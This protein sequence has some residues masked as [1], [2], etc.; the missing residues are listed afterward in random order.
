MLLLAVLEGVRLGTSIVWVVWD[1]GV[2]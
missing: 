1:Q 2:A